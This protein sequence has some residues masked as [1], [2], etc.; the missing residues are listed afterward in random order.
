MPVSANA[1][2][3]SLWLESLGDWAWPGRST[4]GEVLPP[5]W[6]P[7]EPPRLQVALAGATPGAAARTQT[8]L[9]PW[10]VFF[11]GLGAALLAA[12]C[13]LA[14]QGSPTLSDVLGERAAPAAAAPVARGAAAPAAAPGLA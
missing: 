3:A 5:A 4:H 9:R 6:I 12:C 8:R 13:A 2:R 10:R 11:T 7:A 1:S 14:L